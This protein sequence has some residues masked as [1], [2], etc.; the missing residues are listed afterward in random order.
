MYKVGKVAVTS[1]IAHEGM[2]VGRGPGWI[3]DKQDIVEGNQVAGTIMRIDRN[4]AVVDWDNSTVKGYYYSIVGRY[5]LSL[6]EGDV[7]AEAPA[8]K[9]DVYAALR[10]QKVDQ[11]KPGDTVYILPDSGDV[12]PLKEYKD[13]GVIEYGSYKV[14]TVYGSF[15][16]LQGVRNYVPII[17]LQ[18]GFAG[19]STYDRRPFLVPGDKI[20]VGTKL[21]FGMHLDDSEHSNISIG[22]EV[23]V[24]EG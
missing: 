21:I 1:E 22:E 17:A 9:V 12:N 8:K 16:K 10:I 13:L 18:F 24:V 4:S 23:I 20:P 3:Y 5:D 14:V 6:W 2:R 19:L 7:V 15:A 11:L